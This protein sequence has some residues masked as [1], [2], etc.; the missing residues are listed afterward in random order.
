MITYTARPE[1]ADNEHLIFAEHLDTVAHKIELANRKLERNNISERFQ[2]EVVGEWL[3]AL[4]EEEGTYQVRKV[5]S[6]NHPKLGLQG[7]EFI[8]TVAIEEGGTMIQMVPGQETP[9]GYE[10]PDTHNC[11]HCGV[12]R[13]RAKSY[14]VREEATGKVQQ[15]GSTCLEL[16]FGLQIKGLWILNSFTAE[17]LAEFAEEAAN[18]ESS[19]TRVEH[20]YDPRYLIAMA[21]VISNG[22]KGFVSKGS[23]DPEMGRYATAT[24]V[25]ETIHHKPFGRIDYAEEARIEAIR[26]D[27]KD[28]LANNAERVDEVLAFADTLSGDY[29]QNAQ[30]AARSAYVTYRAVGV[31]VSLVGGW[32]RAQAKAAA[33][34]VEKAERNQEFVG[35]VKD[36]LRGLELT[37]TNMREMDSDWGITTLLVM[38]DAANHSFKWFAS[39]AF[40]FE[41]GAQLVLDATV[42]AHETYNGN[43]ETVLT[44]AAIKFVKEA[45]T[46]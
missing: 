33:A 40:D 42:K 23:A 39:K 20:T 44:R 4:D 29:G 37:V 12:R 36:R 27:T 24:T 18:R 5:I 1:L 30:I 15:I 16:F 28:M 43:N 46:A 6:I 17:E 3:D 41:V 11:D 45:A 8:G 19:G 2:M 13:N 38:K 31:L 32:Y 35:Q 34:K 14:L 7:F 9:E 22:G 25:L 21:Y 10:R 26:N